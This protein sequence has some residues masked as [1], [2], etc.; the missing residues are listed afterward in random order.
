[1]FIA[2]LP[3]YVNI[4]KNINIHFGTILICW[5]NPTLAIDKSLIKIN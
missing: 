4:N 3:S 1:M 2:S 5:G